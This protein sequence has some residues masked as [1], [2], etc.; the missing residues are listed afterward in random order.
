MTDKKLIITG[1]HLGPALSVI[2]ELRERRGWKI[3]W[4]GRIFAMEGRDV[5][6]LEGELI[7][8]LGIP[9][10][11]LDT[12][13]LQRKWTKYTITSAFGTLLGFFQ[14]LRILRTIRPDAVLSFGG[15]LSVPVVIAAWLFNVPILIHEQTTTSGLANRIASRF[16]RKIAISF[17]SSTL[18]FSQQKVVMTGNPIRRGILLVKRVPQ[19]RPL[20]YITGGNQGSQVINRAIGRILSKLLLRF[21]VVHQTGFLDYKFFAAK[22]KKLN[23]SLKNHYKPI[24]VVSPDKVGHIYRQASLVIS[25]AGANTVLELAAVGVPAILIPIPWTER[26]EQEKNAR[27]LESTGLARILPQAHLTPRRLWSMISNMIGSP[28]PRGARTSAR[29]LVT[30]DAAARIVTILESFVA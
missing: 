21:S 16:A 6:A 12:G 9:F 22:K 10:F 8:R 27:L 4:I 5:P 28:P 24:A 13:R 17:P 15:Y 26:G 18:D 11:K 2:E 25:R 19:K 14:A 7:P 23:T 3:Y 29:R 30:P 20:V 1:G